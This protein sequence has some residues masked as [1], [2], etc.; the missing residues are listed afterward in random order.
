V[1]WPGAQATSNKERGKLKE[2]IIE[3]F[4]TPFTQKRK[5][6]ITP[7][8]PLFFSNAW[9]PLLCHTFT[10]SEKYS[11]YELDN[12]IHS[13]HLLIKHLMRLLHLNRRKPNSKVEGEG[14]EN[15]TVGYFDYFLNWFT[16]GDGRI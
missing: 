14:N 16:G 5:G 12:Y 7:A 15:I 4:I 2:K 8:A 11:P 3:R 13:Q 10:H 1:S 6:Q 9:Q